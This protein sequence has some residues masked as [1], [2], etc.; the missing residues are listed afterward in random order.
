MEFLVD[1][2]LI[3]TLA[4]LVLLPLLLAHEAVNFIT[5]LI[6]K[7]QKQIGTASFLEGQVISKRR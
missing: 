1:I 6:N 5:R 4:L 7:K 2:I 3:F